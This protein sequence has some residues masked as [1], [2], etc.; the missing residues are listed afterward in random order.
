MEFANHRSEYNRS[1][2]GTVKERRNK[3]EP[4]LPQPR[5]STAAINGGYP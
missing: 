4:I 1:Y 5:K 2:V 3:E